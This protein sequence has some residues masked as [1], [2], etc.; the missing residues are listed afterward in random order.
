MKRI[1]VVIAII[2]SVLFIAGCGG[3]TKE[4][5]EKESF[6]LGLGDTFN[7]GEYLKESE[8]VTENVE[9]GN[10]SVLSFSD[11]ILTAEKTG[12]SKVTA[13][14]EDKN[15]VYTISVVENAVT[16]FKINRGYFYGKKVVF[17]G[18]SISAKVGVTS[19]TDYIDNLTEKLGIN[20]E[21][22]SVG[23]ALYTHWTALGYN[24]ESCCNLI[25]NHS[26][27]N[28]NADYVVL[29]F[30]TNDFGR[31]VNI[32][33]DTDNPQQLNDVKTF[34]GAINFAV[35]K[36]REENPELK[37]L[38]LT[39]LI[40][41]D[42]SLV[43]DIGVS[44]SEYVNAVVRMGELNDARVIDLYN[45]FTAEEIAAGNGYTTDSLHINAKGHLRLSNYILGYDKVSEN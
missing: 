22:F 42:R 38:L 39:P 37:I 5:V 19:G 45:L 11:G 7:I 15:Y 4:T 24:R 25:V 32:G 17:Y 8:I 3:K 30:G 6:V 31:R 36:L 14:T 10:E 40:R 2:L 28:K 23:G 35:R 33:K 20:S 1:S 12:L 9:S 44:L 21:R 41:A 16:E 26:E 13:S 29:F 34:K 43:N 27:Y 18:D